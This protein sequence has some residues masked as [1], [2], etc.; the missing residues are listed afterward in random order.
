MSVTKKVSHRAIKLANTI[1]N[2]T[3]LMILLLFITFGSYAI[4]DSTTI[5]EGATAAKYEIYKPSMENQ[6]SFGE[7]QAINPEVFG[8]LS[9]YGT[10]IDY[11]LVQGEDNAKYINTSVECTYSMTG[12]IF[13]DYSNNRSF[14]DFN[15]IIYGHNM[16]PQ[17]MFG[18]IKS[19]K[20]PQFFESH[21][22]GNLYFD[23][24]DHGIELFAI[25]VADAYDGAIY[26]SGLTDETMKQVYLDTLK[27]KSLLYRDINITSN[28]R[29]VLLSTCSTESTNARD[30]LVGRITN[31]V[32]ND[33]FQVTEEKVVTGID[34]KDGRSIWRIIQGCL[35]IGLPLFILIVILYRTKCRRRKRKKGLEDEQ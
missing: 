24:K 3:V 23:G 6:L 11:P 28:D 7:L 34:G 31:E 33:E 10:M 5:T 27:G 12:A 35:I 15:S 22:Y 13:L 16:V 14:L 17:V 25:I 2:Y 8:W 26:T 21:K 19:F 32:F 20:D 30:I 1:I 9:V 29:I 18:S 4:W